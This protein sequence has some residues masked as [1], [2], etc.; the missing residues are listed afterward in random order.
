MFLSSFRQRAMTAATF[1]TS[2]EG[3]AAAAVP[4]GGT[5]IPAQAVTGRWPRAL[6]LSA[7]SCWLGR[8]LG[9]HSRA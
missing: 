1:V 5:L 7:G 2:R 3:R 4:G 8:P 6:R 9:E